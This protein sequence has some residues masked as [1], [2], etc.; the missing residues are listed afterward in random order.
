MKVLVIQQRYGIGDMVILLPYIKAISRKYGSPITL[1]SK[2]SSKASD[3]LSEEKFVNEIIILDKDKD[4]MRGFFK[5]SNEI[6]KRKFDKVFIFNSSLRY[7]LVAR[8][9]GI[10][11]IFQYPLFRKKDNIF[12]SA[13][14][15][16]ESII[17]E[18]ISSEP[19]IKVK[20]YK[21]EIDKSLKHIC[22][23]ISASGPTKIW[24]IDNY[25][26]LCDELTKIYDCKFY[27]A[28]GTNDL[29]L[30]DEFKKKS[31]NKKF[32]SFEKLT[33]KETLPIIKNCNLYIG[34]DTG[35]AH[36]AVALNVK[37]L[38]L[39]VDSPV[40][41]YGRYS[42][43]MTTIEPQGEIN[44]TTHDT[45]GKEKISFDEVLMTAKKLLV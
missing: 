18:K 30:I 28:G 33:I 32:Y 13:Q 27:L 11:S 37:A 6:R 35:W 40:L 29:N 9:S 22:L 34:N 2:A 20:N 8:I 14:E 1:L 7:Y 36:I 21:N 43:K 26:K 15:F 39:F 44:S 24:K 16:T 12:K 31:K 10:K 45:L 5:L 3:L 23:G 25:I 19:T 42:S 17:G 4:G 41:A 38:T